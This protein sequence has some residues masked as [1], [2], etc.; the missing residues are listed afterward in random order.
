MS[1]AMSMRVTMPTGFLFFALVFVF[2]S[3]IMV[4]SMTVIMSVIV[5]GL[6]FVVDFESSVIVGVQDFDLNK[7]EEEA[8]DG[9]HQH[10]EAINLSWF[11]KPL[12]CFD[13]QP[14]R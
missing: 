1:M 12:S 13:E 9:C 14:N 11:E 7:V 4:V 3:M 8:C 10:P 5:L 2:F 6:F